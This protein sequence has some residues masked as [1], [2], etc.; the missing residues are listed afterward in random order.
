MFFFTTGIYPKALSLVY[1][2]FLG[3]TLS[4]LFQ[5]LSMY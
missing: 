5:K 3:G 4:S 1:G 2:Q